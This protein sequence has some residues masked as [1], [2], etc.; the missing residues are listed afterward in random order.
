MIRTYTYKIKSTKAIDSKFNKWLGITR[1]VYNVAKE[2]REESYRK[3]VKINYFD[4]SKQL[5]EAKKEFEWIRQVGSH[6]LQSTLE[7]L[8]SSY[9]KFFRGGGYPNWASKRKWNS[10]HFKG[11]IQ[12]GDKGFILPKFGLVKVFNL[13]IPK[14]E[15]KTA[16]IIEEADGLYLKIV[17]RN[18]I[19]SDKS[20]ENQSICAVDM[21][22]TNFLTTSDG[23]VIDNPRHL[24]K[25]LK[26]LRT[27]QRRL[28]RMKRG[29]K[30]Y[31]KQCKRIQLIHLK[32]RRSRE[33]FLHKQSSMLSKIYSTIIVEDLNISGMIK[34]KGFSKYISDCSWATFFKLITYKT[35]VVKVNP[36]YTSQKCSKCKHIDRGN[37]KSQSQFK[38]V[39][40]GYVENADLQATYN[41][42][43]LGYQLM[44]ANVNQ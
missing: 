7:R 12:I 44:G 4:L 33:D 29:G 43:E 16:C 35:N 24:F 22:I 21:G 14:G 40:C 36:A 9:K 3:G 30:N 39:K 26:S 17:V 42:L 6:T 38:C 1:Y 18:H 23:L 8:E 32:V 31:K 2:C 15:I 5:T 20:R 27:E 11:N 34:N 19:V 37:R 41:L 25:H 28:C 10:V 13:R